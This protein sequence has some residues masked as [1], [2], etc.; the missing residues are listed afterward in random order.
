MRSTGT[1]EASRARGAL[2]AEEEQ[3]IRDAVTW[4]RAYPTDR[5]FIRAGDLLDHGSLLFD[6][7]SH[8][9]NHS[10]AAVTP[11]VFAKHWSLTKNGARRIDRWDG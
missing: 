10:L 9:R 11:W 2:G 3:A 5:I 4:T 1:L 8:A 6:I 7:I